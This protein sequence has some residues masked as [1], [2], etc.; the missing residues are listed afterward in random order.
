MPENRFF[1]ASTILL[2]LLISACSADRGMSPDELDDFA[3]RYTEAWNSGDPNAVASFYAESGSLQVNNAD[4]AVGRDAVAEVAK[5]FFDDF[6]DMR[7]EMRELEIGDELVRYH[8]RFTGTN[9]GPGG[10]GAPVDVVGYEQWTM[11]EDGFIAQS[12]GFFDAEDYQAQLN[13]PRP[14]TPESSNAD[15][16]A[17]MLQHEKN[18]TQTSALAENFPDLSRERAYDI[19]K[20]RLEQTASDEN[21]HVGWK[22]GWTRLADPNE[23]LDPIVGHYLASRVFEAGQPLSTRHF[24]NG[25]ANAEPEIVFYLGKDLPGP[26]HTR[27]EVIDAIEG[28]GIAMEF[29]NWRAMEPR[30]REHAIADNGIAA[31]VVLADR[32][33]DVRDLNFTQIEGAVTVNSAETSTGRTTSIMGKD[34]IEGLVWAANE[35]LKYGM[36]LKA[37]QFVVSGTVCPPLPV[38]AGD[39]ANIAFTGMGSLTVQFSE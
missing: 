14:L 29:V 33:Y 22:L 1:T 10:T 28:V 23:P 13:R 7:V 8:W 2:A 39:T 30:T 18:Q 11:S 17:H 35:L 9:T 3:A 5:G 20:L 12:L 25:T 26:T 38:S 27:A 37:G 6:P 36:H 34:P 19:Q 21:P 15:V 24:T 4:P 31:G 32:R 16:V